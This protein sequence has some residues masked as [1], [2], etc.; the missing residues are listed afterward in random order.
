MSI[1][2]GTNDIMKMVI[3]KSLLSGKTQIG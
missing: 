3:A 1:G 2:E